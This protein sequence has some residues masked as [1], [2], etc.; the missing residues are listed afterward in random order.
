MIISRYPDSKQS[1]PMVGKEL[2]RRKMKWSPL[3]VYLSLSST[4]RGKHE[5]TTYRGKRGKRV[6]SKKVRLPPSSLRPLD[7]FIL[8][9]VFPTKGML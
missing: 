8:S 3:P 1:K 2:G 9:P 6:K 5:M 4:A 7:I